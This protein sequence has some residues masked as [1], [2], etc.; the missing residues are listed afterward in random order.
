MTLLEVFTSKGVRKNMDEK[1]IQIES[2]TYKF[3]VEQDMWH[4]QLPKSQTR[5]RDV[6]QLALISEGTEFFV[7]A[8]VKDGE[9]LITFS[10]KID[11]GKRKWK[12]IQKLG[13][14]D[15]YWKIKK[16][17]SITYNLLFTPR[18]FSFR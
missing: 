5:V 3:S 9:D 11:E 13:R 14:H 12:D 1:I 4:L 7:P 16:Y 15:Q 8:S 6:R 2:M 17:L 18:Q 10:F